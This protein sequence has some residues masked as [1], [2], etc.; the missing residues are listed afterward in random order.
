MTL[1]QQ[2]KQQGSGGCGSSSTSSEC[3]VQL[4]KD[5]VMHNRRLMT[6][7]GSPRGRLS[8]HLVAQEAVYFN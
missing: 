2:K 1:Q 7:Q 6:Q 8:V 5:T 3:Y 4:G